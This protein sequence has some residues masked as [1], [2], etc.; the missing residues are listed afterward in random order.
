MPIRSVYDVQRRERMSRL[1]WYSVCLLVTLM[2]AGLASR[3]APQQ[4]SLAF[5]IFV[6]GLGVAV[7]R[8]VTGLYLTIFLAVLGDPGPSWWYPFTKNLSSRESVLFINDKL[9]FNPLELYLVALAFGFLLQWMS[10]RQPVFYRGKLFWPI[11]VFS[12][13]L[14]SAWPT[15]WLGAVSQHPPSGRSGRCCTFRSSTCWR[16]TCSS[17]GDS[18]KSW[19]G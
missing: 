12:G 11:M 6:I 7:V 9:I 14:V 5:F 15:G 4:F 2:I 16:R 1:W 10:T 17:A 13:F 3:T 8:P 18:T 19:R